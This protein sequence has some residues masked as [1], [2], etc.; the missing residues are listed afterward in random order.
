V[1]RS[2]MRAARRGLAAL[3]LCAALAAGCSPEARVERHRARADELAAKGDLA[4]ATLELRSALQIAPGDVDVALR[5][6]SLL[7]AT[8]QADEARFFY[9]EAQRF[10]PERSDVALALAG[11]LAATD[12]QR[13]EALV[14]AVLARDPKLPAASVRQ[15]ELALRR[16]DDAAAVAAAERAV[17]LAPDDASARFARGRARQSALAARWRKG[18]ATGDELYAEVL[19]DLDVAAAGGDAPLRAR[20]HAARARLFAA[21]P[22]HAEDADR[23]HRARIEAA[24]ASGYPGAP[25][26]AA[27]AAALYASR[28]GNQGLLEYALEQAVRADPSRESAWRDLAQAEER[29]GRS[30]EPV[31]ARILTERPGDPAAI[32]LHAQ[33]LVERGRVDEAIASLESAADSLR[34]PA[35]VLEMLARVRFDYGQDE[36]GERV[37]ER[38]RR[39]HEGAPATKRALAREALRAGRGAEALPLLAELT[40]SED[41]IETQTL[42]A[43]AELSVGRI[44]EATDAIERAKELG[45]RDAPRVLRV[46]MRVDQAAR[47]WR[48]VLRDLRAMRLR[49]VKPNSAE[50][51]IVAEALYELGRPIPARRLLEQLLALPEPP[52][53]AALEFARREGKADP[54]RAAALLESAAARAP[55]DARL[56]LAVAAAAAERGDAERASAWLAKADA[57]LPAP[58]PIPFA[59]E[60]ARILLV[61]KED[62]RAEAELLALLERAPELRPALDLLAELHRRAGTLERALA[63][64]EARAAGGERASERRALL[65]R[66]AW[67]AGRR[68]VARAAFERALVERSDLAGVKRDLAALLLETG[69]DLAKARALAS[70]ARA[71]LPRDPEAARVLG[72]ALL[73]SGEAAAALGE[74]DAAASLAAGGADAA[75]ETLRGLALE[76]LGRKGE[77]KTAFEAALRREPERQDARDG[78]ARV[79]NG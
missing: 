49:N 65:G 28:S 62:A 46:E 18:E 71:A 70:E 66:L 38:L 53:S 10:A 23:A 9:E 2:G 36:A 76:A 42:L 48:E 21:W 72:V 33:L 32:T 61:A 58:A 57:A 56:L 50:L 6:G 24:F 35:D 4:A 15:S 25:F 47:R 52:T 13:A 68:D 26:S 41:T 22:G 51:V 69:A 11:A 1:T 54:A 8:G 73:R 40:A 59:L 63:D 37:L 17:A 31:L 30:A 64:L 3:A 79:A 44:A 16:G 60:R 78:L 5:L 67:R 27:R 39:D 77:A 75:L 45:G 43:A 14:E 20:A 55:G 29:A 34:E 74:L 7:E 19:A 12:A